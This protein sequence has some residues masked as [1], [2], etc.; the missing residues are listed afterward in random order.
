MNNFISGFFYPFKCI[1]LF[2]RYPKLIAYS[3]VPVIVNMIIYGTVFYLT[4]NWITGKTEDAVGNNASDSFLFELIQTFLKLF[5]FLLVLIVCYFL[6]VIF[7]GIIS[8]PFNEKISKLIEEKYFRERVDN[9]LPFIKD[10]T[11]SITAELKKIL[12]YFS[13]MIPLLLIDFIPMIG[14]VITL[15]FGT[16]F[17]FFYNALDYLDYP[18]TRRMT[19]FREK[20]KIVASKRMLSFG[21]GAIAFLL[22]FLPVINVLMKPLLVASGTSLFYEKGYKEIISK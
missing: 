8:A 11:T 2:F 17:S 22:T 20:L 5:T 14:G 10:I 19:V 13:I 7:G 3:I 16:G 21:F 9:N 18:L 1:K 12:F 15:V 6:F 4:Y